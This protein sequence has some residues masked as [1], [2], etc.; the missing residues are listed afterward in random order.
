MGVNSLEQGLKEW[1]NCMNPW[2]VYNSLGWLKLLRDGWRRRARSMQLPSKIS[3]RSDGETGE[4]RRT[5]KEGWAGGTA[6][7]DCKG[8]WHK[9][10]H[11]E[12]GEG[13]GR[14]LEGRMSLLTATSKRSLTTGMGSWWRWQM[15]FRWTKNWRW[16]SLRLSL[17]I[18]YHRTEP[19]G[20][21]SLSSN[22]RRGIFS[23]GW[24]VEETLR[25]RRVE[26]DCQGVFHGELSWPNNLRS[27]IVDE[28]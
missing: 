6:V 7:R 28:M 5:D 18:E 21:W 14:G 20:A 13:K 2:L 12:M 9:E 25:I 8:Y 17:R 26:L 23:C 10:M 19:F 15:N 4:G 22:G 24:N 16:W 11:L 27:L 1:L 3:W